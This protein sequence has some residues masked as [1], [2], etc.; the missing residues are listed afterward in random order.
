MASQPELSTD[1]F[2]LKLGLFYAAYFLY[3]GIQLPFFPVWL[4]ARGLEAATIGLVIAVPMMVRVVAMPLITRAADRTRAIK[5]TLVIAAAAAACAMT[6]VGLAAD[7]AAIFVAFTIAA[8]AVSPVLSLADAYALTG[9]GARGRAYGPVRLWGSVA[10]IAA[11]VGAGW[12]LG[13]IAPVHLVWLI[14]AALAVTMIAA[15]GLEPLGAAALPAGGA[16]SPPRLL[17]RNGA[18]IAVAAAASLT[19][20]SHALFYGFSALEWR[21]AGLNG[22][23]IGMLWGIGVVAEI[24]LFAFSARLPWAPGVLLAAGAAGAVLRW[25]AMAF[26][27]PVAALGALQCLH[28]ASFGAAHLGAMGFLARAVPKDLAATAQGMVA[29]VSGIVMASATV[30]SGW[31]YAGSGSFAYLAM[32]GMGVAGFG[33]A[34]IAHRLSR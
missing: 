10:F 34:L 8:I 7:V 4:E 6:V 17:W 23:T 20:G 22:V 18:L 15:A 25:T 26:E 13:F 24:A 14:V 28:A 12:L 11:N 3:G 2:A 29:T 21:A 9:L 30:L 19:Q 33:C 27:P 5:A 16:P 1:R 31:L 32:A